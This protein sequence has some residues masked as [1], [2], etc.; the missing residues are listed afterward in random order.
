MLIA[1]HKYFAVHEDQ[2]SVS[3]RDVSRFIILYKW[4][5]Q[6]ITDKKA[7]ADNGEKSERYAT[8]VAKFKGLKVLRYEQADI[9]IELYSNILALCHCYYLRI[10]SL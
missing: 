6:S 10:S 3:L 4:F 5:K 9:D 8:N 2:S 7:Q 1:C